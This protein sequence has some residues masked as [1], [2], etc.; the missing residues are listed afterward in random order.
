MEERMPICPYCGQDTVWE[1]RLRSAP[2]PKFRMCFECDSVWRP[3]EAI[4]DKEG[5]NFEEYM[6]ELGR[7]ADWHDVEKISAAGP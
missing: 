3:G 1:A 5:T 4:S 2:Q 7:I 6:R